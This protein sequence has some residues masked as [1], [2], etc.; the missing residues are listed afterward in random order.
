MLNVKKCEIGFHIY[1][2]GRETFA[3]RVLSVDTNH[4]MENNMLSVQRTVESS[5]LES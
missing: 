5:M 3:S 4:M 2:M 1:E